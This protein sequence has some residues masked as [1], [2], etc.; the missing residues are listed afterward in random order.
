MIFFHNIPLYCSS[1]ISSSLICNSF[2][3]WFINLFICVPYSI[4]SSNKKIKY[5]K[6]IAGYIKLDTDL[7]EYTSGYKQKEYDFEASDINNNEH[8]SSQN[9]PITYY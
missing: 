9:G 4:V 1:S 5:G 7:K 8:L 6:P 3:T 2:D